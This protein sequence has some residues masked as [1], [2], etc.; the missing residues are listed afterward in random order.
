MNLKQELKNG[1]KKIGVWGVGYIGYSSMAYFAKEGV[2]CIGTD[3]HEERVKDVN[4]EGKCVIPNMDYWLAFDVAPLIKSKLMFATTDWKELIKEEVGAHLVAIPTEKNGKPYDDILIDVIEKI[5]DG[6]KELN[7]KEPPLIIIESTLT[8]NRVEKIILPIFEKKGIKVGEGGDI[9][10]GVAPRRDWFVSADKTLKTLPRVAGGTD[11]YTTNIMSEILGI[12]SDIM[13][14]ATDHNHACIV[15]SVENAF[16]QL[17]ITFANQLSLA[18]PDLNMVEIL[19][20]AGTKWNVGTYHPSFGI[21]GYCIPLA[22]Q[23]VLEG[24][25]HPE[26]LTLLKASLETDFSQPQ[27]VVDK[28]VKE[29]YK[30]I[31]LL[32][33]AYTN[34]LK[35][36]VL[37]PTISLVK[38][39]KEANVEVKVHDPL[40]NAEE[41]KELCGAESFNF[42]EDMNNFDAILVVSPHMEYKFTNHNKITRNLANCKLIL[43]NMGCWNEVNFPD[44]IEYHEA[45]DANWLEQRGDVKNEG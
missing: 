19:K 6:Y 7:C 9:L 27:R 16:R 5:S 11:K 30:K 20:M 33:L 8:P 10:L 29:G 36:H 44:A 34:D 40:Y 17:E 13:I 45:G 23:Y 1:T 31:G 26:K 3:P 32:G 4:T 15:K 43:D 39:L 18:Y 21:G 25:K 12:I 28:L 24:A 38:G 37:S 2:A 14:K 41:I 42:P 35:V 22:P